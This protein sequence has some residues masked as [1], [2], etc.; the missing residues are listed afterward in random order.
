MQVPPSVG[1]SSSDAAYAEKPVDECEQHELDSG[2]P[3]NPYL[4][5]EVIEFH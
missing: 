2:A 4:V 3:P 1:A 5:D